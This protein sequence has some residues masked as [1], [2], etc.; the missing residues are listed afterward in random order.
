MILDAMDKKLLLAVQYQCNHTGLAIPWNDIGTLMGPKITGGA[1]IQHLAKMRTRMIAQNLSVPPPLKRGGGS[2][3]IS[4]ATTSSGPTTTSTKKG[5]GKANQTS[6]KAMPAKSKKAAKKVS[7]DSD[8]SDEDDD[9]DAWKD[10]DS[11]AEYG[12]PRPKRT[13]TTAKESTKRKF[14]AEDSD[15]EVVL[16][17]NAPKRKQKTSKSSSRELSAYG[18]TDINGVPLDYGTDTEDEASAELVGAGEPWLDLEDD[19]A[20]HPKTG[21]K[22]PFKKSLVVALPNTPQ[23]TEAAGGMSEDESEDE[24]AGGGVESFFGGSQVSPI[25]QLNNPYQMDQHAMTYNGGM[26]E[27]EA[28]DTNSLNY[29][30]NNHHGGNT[31]FDQMTSNFRNQSNSGFADPIGSFGTDGGA[32]AAF[33]M[34]RDNSQA[35]PYQLQTS[36]PST[37][38]SYTSLNQ[39]PAGTSAGADFGTEYFGHGQFDLLDPF[40]DAN[41]DFSATD[42]GDTFFNGEDFDGPFFGNGY[43]GSKHYGH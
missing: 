25:N 37:S 42:G 29:M 27:E 13:K 5:K 18:T 9:D 6:T 14:K 39:T 38:S 17:D 12:E 32:G 1:V 3:R 36:W 43:L 19:Y 7:P 40:G 2:A 16:P 24:V 22:T 31:N 34:A 35:V 8:E 23:K 15:E 28:N 20:S 11:D 10:D 4:T 21:K 30:F 33:P 26:Y 41:M